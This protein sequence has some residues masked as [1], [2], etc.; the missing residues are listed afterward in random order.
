[1]SADELLVRRAVVLASALVYWGGVWVQARRVR[2]RIGRS[3]SLKPRSFKERLLW[4]GWF[5][6]VAGWIALP[7]MAHPGTESAW[8]RPVPSIPAMWGMLAGVI[9]IVLGYAGTLWCYSAMGEHW[10]IMVD[11][12]HKSALV[13]GGPYR[14]VRHP[15]YLFQIIMLVGVL[16]LLPTALSLVLLL[17]HLGCTL[18]KAW[19]EEAFLL[20]THGEP[21][22][23]YMARTGMLLPCLGRQS[24]VSE[25]K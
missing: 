23:N 7:L 8:I 13:T 19:D 24:R 14:V 22:Q 25:N 21:Y 9:L 1:M 17:I 12:R 4:L 5:V 18:V 15:I 6:V 20:E 2:K 11:R 10:R 3:P 16:V